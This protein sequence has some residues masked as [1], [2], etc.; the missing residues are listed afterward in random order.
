[1]ELKEAPARGEPG[2]LEES[3]EHGSSAKSLSC[4]DGGNGAIPCANPMQRLQRQSS[5][6]PIACMQRGAQVIGIDAPP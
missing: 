3:G 1:M 6:G 4:T 2:G 5:A